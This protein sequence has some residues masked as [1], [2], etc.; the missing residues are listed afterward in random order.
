MAH[1]STGLAPAA[2]VHCVNLSQYCTNDVSVHCLISE[3][4]RSVE[5]HQLE[6]PVA[7]LTLGECGAA[8]T[9]VGTTSLPR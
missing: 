1:C 5:G 3:C 9:S 2:G 7:K 4:G 6:V 8:V